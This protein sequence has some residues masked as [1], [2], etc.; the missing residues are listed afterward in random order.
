MIAE[1]HIVVIESIMVEELPLG[2]AVRRLDGELLLSHLRV[3]YLRRYGA[4]EVFLNGDLHPI[5]LIILLILFLDVFIICKPG[6]HYQLGR[7]I[8]KVGEWVIAKGALALAIYKM[9]RSNLTLGL[10][11]GV[12]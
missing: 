4:C 6:T 3:L 1:T 10:I 8:K 9:T 2:N 11:Q 12:L 5:V 7:H